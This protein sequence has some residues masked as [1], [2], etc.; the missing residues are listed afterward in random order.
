MACSVPLLPLPS[1]PQGTSLLLIIQRLCPDE[2][3]DEMQ[4]LKVSKSSGSESNCPG[5]EEPPLIGGG[6]LDKSFGSLSLSFLPRI[7]GT[8]RVNH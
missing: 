8:V 4:Y 5:L 3:E 7:M 1:P 2:K 6:I